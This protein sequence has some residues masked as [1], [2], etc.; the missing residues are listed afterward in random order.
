[1]TNDSIEITGP[2]K[3]ILTLGL[4]VFCITGCA[5]APQPPVSLSPAILEQSGT[6]VGIATTA[7]PEVSMIYPGADCLACF[8][9]AAV[10]NA[11]LSGHAKT[12]N[13][14]DVSGFDDLIKERLTQSG[15]SAKFISQDLELKKFKSIRSQS[16][17]TAKRDFSPLGDEHDITH[18]V[19]INIEHLGFVRHYATYIPTSDPQASMK[20][21]AYMVNLAD[22]TYSWYLP[23]EL[24]HSARG[25]WKEPPSFP[26]LTNAYYSVVETIKDDLLDVFASS[27]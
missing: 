19:V 13:A 24:Y 23:I 12:L 14:E 5:V 10:A 1:M 8:F 17:N 18:L 6:R 11:K 15:V 25:E 2:M 27:D 26:G 9:A 21:A 20:G 3:K 16:S 22:N 7:I 4:I